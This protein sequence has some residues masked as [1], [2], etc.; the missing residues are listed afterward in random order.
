VKRMEL[1]KL[2]VPAGEVR[3]DL[4]EEAL[5]AMLAAEKQRQAVMFE[6]FARAGGVTEFWALGVQVLAG[7]D[8]V[9]S[10][11][12]HDERL[13]M[14]SSR[15][16]GSLDGAEAM[17]TDGSQAWSPGRAMFMPVALAGLATKAVADAAVVF[18]DGV[19][20]TYPL[21]GNYEVREAQKQV[22]QFNALAGGARPESGKTD[23]GPA[24]RLRKLEELREAGLLSQEEYAAKR[25]EIISSI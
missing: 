13:K 2:G 21:E 7:D 8:Q 25:A 4:A 3:E 6:R 20:H 19:V 5:D 11:G 22:V 1:E 17:V 10:I 15:L 16:L 18:P 12:N 9:Y 24:V 14:N 23:T